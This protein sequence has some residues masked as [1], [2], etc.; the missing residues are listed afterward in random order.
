MLATMLVA[1]AL[2]AQDPGAKAQEK[3]VPKDAQADTPEQA[4]RSFIVAWMTKDAVA[5]RAVTLP[6]VDLELIMPPQPIPPEALD[7]FKAQIAKLSVRILKAGEEVKLVGD[8]TYKARPEDVGPDRAVVLPGNAA[9]PLLSRKV[10]GRWRI[11]VSPI[12]ASIKAAA[13]QGPPPAP[14]TIDPGPI[15]D[16]L[17]IKPG[18]EI[19]VQFTRDGDAISAPKVVTVPKD[20]AKADPKTEVVHFDFSKK[21]DD[22]MLTTQNPYSKNLV[23]RA[24]ARH[25]DRTTYVETSIVPVN[26]GIFGIE[27]WREPIEELLLFDFKLVDKKR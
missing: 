6:V 19:R 9:Y 17:T 15:K 7:A 21:G 2:A 3:P 8:R 13:G 16:K 12:V 24:A 11:D 23:F 22:L 25:K 14:K 18:Q 4:I 10:E 1:L 5:L 27:M 20:E 26:A